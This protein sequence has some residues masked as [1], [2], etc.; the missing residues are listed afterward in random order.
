MALTLV[1]AFMPFFTRR[2]ASRDIAAQMH[3]TTEQID[4]AKIAAKIYVRENADVFPYNITILSG[5]VFSDTL[6]PYGLPMGF[7]PRTALGQD[8]SLIINK[9]E[10][11]VSA[12]L[13][14]S[15]GDKLTVMQR[16]EL[17]H[18]I[19]FFAVYDPET[20]HDIIDVGI[21]L[22]DMYSDVVLRNDTNA[23][24]S[25]FLSD[26]EMNGNNLDNVGTL[27]GDVAEFETAGVGTLTLTGNESGRKE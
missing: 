8:I 2:L 19:G 24:A 27:R 3:A 22:A 13:R 21:Q 25:G 18:R 23:F 16:A 7:V 10:Q 9:N 5:D 11:E 6:E 20:S 14:I 17:A 26:L 4:A 12:V 15:G 1:F